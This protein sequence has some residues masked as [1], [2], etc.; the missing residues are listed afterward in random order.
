MLGFRIINSKY[1]MYSHFHASTSEPSLQWPF[2]KFPMQM[3][4]AKAHAAISRRIFRLG[5][6]TKISSIKIEQAYG[7]FCGTR[8]VDWCGCIRLWYYV[9]HIGHQWYMFTECQLSSSKILQNHKAWLMPW[10]GVSNWS[11]IIFYHSATLLLTP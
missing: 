9:F 5:F 8:C 4:I 3:A 7:G 10:I 6:H 11:W 2:E 1:Q